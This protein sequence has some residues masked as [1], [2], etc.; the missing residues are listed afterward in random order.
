MICR[1]NRQRK[2]ITDFK[3]EL[4][5][6]NPQLLRFEQLQTLQAN[7]GNR[8]NQS[9]THCHVQAGPSGKKIMPKEVMEKIIDFSRSYPGLCIDITGGCP[10]LNPDFK[11]FLDSIYETASPLMVR[12][13][14][15]VFFEPGL[16]W[17][18]GWYSKHKVVLIASLPCHTDEN[19]DQQRGEGAFKKSIAALKILNELGYGIDGQPELNLVYNPGG[20]FLPGPQA[21][22]EADYKRELGKKYG[23]KF[24]NLFT[25]TNAPIGRFKRYLKA[26]GKLEQYLQLLKENFNPDAAE[27]IMCRRLISIDYKGL[28]YNCDFNQALNLPIIDSAGKVVSIERLKDVL[29]EDIEIITGEHCFCCT[30]GTGSSCKGSLVK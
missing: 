25:I 27:N 10:E 9:C 17:V 2:M 1:L 24:N 13:N 4:E 11:F 12:T 29:S 21:Q 5:N 22:L 23:V 14:L 8:C 16:N 20:D 6:S 18:P 7:L 30:A 26:N 28:A 19:V 3:K 15:T